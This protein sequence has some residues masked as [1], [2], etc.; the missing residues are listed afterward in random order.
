M[1]ISSRLTVIFVEERIFLDRITY[2]FPSLPPSLSRLRTASREHC[3]CYCPC[4][5]F[6]GDQFKCKRLISN[7]SG[8]LKKWVFIRQCLF[9]GIRKFQSF[10]V[11]LLPWKGIRDGRTSWSG[12]G[13]HKYFMLVFSVVLHVPRILI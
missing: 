3:F 4:Q 9:T 5:A 8:E 12:K 1:V 10:A 13:Y 6:P 7:L 11:R 2:Q